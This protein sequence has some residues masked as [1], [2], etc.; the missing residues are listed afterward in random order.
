MEDQ[1]SKI[2]SDGA[3]DA[4]HDGLDGYEAYERS[5]GHVPAYLQ[6]LESRIWSSYTRG[7]RNKGPHGTSTWKKKELRLKLKGVSLVEESTF[8][9]MTRLILIAERIVESTQKM[10]WKTIVE[11]AKV[12]PDDST[13]TQAECTTAVEAARAICRLAQTGSSCFD[14][15]WNLIKDWS[16]NKTRARNRIKE[17]YEGRWKRKTKDEEKEVARLSHLL[18][19]PVHAGIWDSCSVEEMTSN[20]HYNSGAKPKLSAH[21]E[22][23][24]MSGDE[25]SAT[26]IKPWRDKS[27]WRITTRKTIEGLSDQSKCGA[28]LKMSGFTPYWILAFF[29]PPYF[30]DVFTP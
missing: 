10:K 27:L 14:M 20:K 12:L 15:D 9:V 19:S 3:K 8:N 11:V 29:G 28:Y 30:L 4:E 22:W 26:P 13:I 5:S 7:K 2:Q 18:S 17:D 23:P 24:N 6:R 16:G 21:A 25:F 1:Q